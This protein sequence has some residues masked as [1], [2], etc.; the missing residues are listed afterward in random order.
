[1][2]KGF[3][4]GILDVKSVNNIKSVIVI[5]PMIKGD[6]H[7]PFN[8]ALLASLISAFPK[9]SITFAGQSSHVELVRSYLLENI[10]GDQ[11][12]I[13]W[14][15]IKTLPKESSLSWKIFP[16]QMKMVLQFLEEIDLQ[17]HS[18]LLF[19]SL[20]LVGVLILKLLLYLRKIRLPVLIISHAHAVQVAREKGKWRYKIFPWKWLMN[21]THIISLP[22][23][24]KLKFV[25]LGES[26]FREFS[27]IREK[28]SSHFVYMDHPY[29]W[30]V[31]LPHIINKPSHPIRFG[32]FGVGNRRKG[33]NEFMNFVDEIIEIKP[34]IEFD[35]VGYVP[36]KSIRVSK[37][38][39][40]IPHSPLSREEFY[41][42]TINLH[43]SLYL[44]PPSNYRYRASATFLDSLSFGKPGIY[45]RNPYIEYYFD[46][47]GDIGYLCDSYE[48]V[49]EVVLSIANKFPLERYNQQVKN[50]F[51]QRKIFE[52]EI[53][54]IRLRKIIQD[55]V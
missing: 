11:K 23:P 26:L 38:V 29:F 50:I 14:K 34:E 31:E 24:G 48:E 15:E 12:N 37:N 20:S 16:R 55:M 13:Q 32:F 22:H 7:L 10:S 17:K 45:I 30:S 40:G 41:T 4:I 8:A 52:P 1:M 46:K 9:V 33:I 3:G 51:S 2:S 39:R 53:V 43:Y 49:R 5:D 18:L 6:V 19:N 21:P 44:S 28:S 54:G 35:V 36:D 42:R 25:L 47:M 27:K